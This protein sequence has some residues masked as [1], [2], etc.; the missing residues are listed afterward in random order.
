MAMISESLESKFRSISR[1]RRGPFRVMAYALPQTEMADAD[2]EKTLRDGILKDIPV[3]SLRIV[4]DTGTPG[5]SALERDAFKTDVL[6]GIHPPQH[7]NGTG[8]DKQDRVLE[9]KKEEGIRI[10]LRQAVAGLPDLLEEVDRTLGKADGT[11]EGKASE[12]SLEAPSAEETHVVPEAT[13]QESK[14]LELPAPLIYF[15]SFEDLGIDA[16][17][18]SQ[19]LG[20]LIGQECHVVVSKDG[21]DT[22]TREGR[23]VARAALRLGAIR[24]TSARELSKLEF[25]NRREN[26][27]V[28]GPIPYGFKRVG[29]E[30][31]PVDEEVSLVKRMRDLA[32]HGRKPADILTTLNRER[33]A[34]KDGTPWTWRRVSQVLKNPIYEKLA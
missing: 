24:S 13:A 22:R 5:R 20:V 26:L 23:V 28:Y 8:S 15:S 25:K 9:I 10:R 27:R 4:I 32:F 18:I 1:T 34:W 11:T 17:R 3:D 7:P 30:L 19:V 16:E 2:L 21:L 33:Q 31:E 6:S 29:K 12:T 14:P